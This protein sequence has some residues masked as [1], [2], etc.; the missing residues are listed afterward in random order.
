M[1]MYKPTPKQL[2][3]HCGQNQ[4]LL[5]F[6]VLSQ[7]ALVFTYLQT[8]LHRLVP[9]GLFSDNRLN[10]RDSNYH[11]Q[12]R[13]Y[14]ENNL[15][16]DCTYRGKP[17]HLHLRSNYDPDHFLVVA[18][19]HFIHQNLSAFSIRHCLLPEN[20]AFVGKA[21]LMPTATQVVSIL[22]MLKYET[23]FTFVMDGL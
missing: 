12:S 6:I 16:I 15:S 18:S 17:G 10:G 22:K 7:K 21:N 3:F 4:G 19:V 2:R 20:A 8:F 14:I 23:V 11:I 1:R 13:A 9:S 5:W